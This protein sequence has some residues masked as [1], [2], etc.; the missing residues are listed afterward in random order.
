MPESRDMEHPWGK[1]THKQ[2]V[3]FFFLNSISPL[4]GENGN[5][6]ERNLL[7]HL[8]GILPPTVNSTSF[9]LRVH[10]FC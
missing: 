10:Y 3:I 1:L 9:L 2:F 6:T 7:T 5:W 8:A 4:E